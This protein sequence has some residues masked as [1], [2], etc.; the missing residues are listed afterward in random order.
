MLSKTFDVFHKV[1][2][3]GHLRATG[4]YYADFARDN[5]KIYG[6]KLICCLEDKNLLKVRGLHFDATTH[7][8][9]LKDKA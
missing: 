6:E 3:F 2:T 1:Y 8:S 5:L 7:Y 9:Y 4:L